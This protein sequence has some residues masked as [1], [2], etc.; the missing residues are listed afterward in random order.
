MAP[1]NKYICVHTPVC[2]HSPTKENYIWE[3]AIPTKHDEQLKNT[4]ESIK[5]MHTG[6]VKENKLEKAIKQIL[7]IT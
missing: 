2:C 1:F 5:N 6:L 7:L 4:E 3:Q